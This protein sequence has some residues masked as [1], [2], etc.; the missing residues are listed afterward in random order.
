MAVVVVVVVVVGS[1]SSRNTC[2]SHHS[3][4]FALTQ[5]YLDIPEISSTA[6]VNDKS[7]R[8]GRQPH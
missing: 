6:H 7:H 4:S 3:R 1:I 5:M 8:F 2:Y